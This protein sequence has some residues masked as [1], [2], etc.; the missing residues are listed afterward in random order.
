MFIF[1]LRL[2]PPGLGGGEEGVGCTHC[3][4]FCMGVCHWDFVTFTLYQTMSP[5]LLYTV[6]THANI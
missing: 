1:S 5:G 3:L 4:D 6:I 2:Y